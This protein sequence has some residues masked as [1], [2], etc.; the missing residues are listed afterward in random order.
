MR[1][2]LFVALRYLTA[3]RGE[4]FISLIS[5]M[6]VLG[7]VVGVA[8]IIVVQGVM[9]GFDTELKDKIIGANSHILIEA[10]APIE[11]TRFVMD[12]LRDTAG[13]NGASKF[14]AGQVILSKDKTVWGT[15]L[16]GINPATETGVTK[17]EEYLTRG[18]LPV[19]GGVVLGSELADRFGVDV[20]SEIDIISPAVSGK[21]RFHV[22]GIF[23][24]G[25]Y[26]YD[27]NLILAHIKDAQRLFALGEA[28]TGIGV[29]I[30]DPYRARALENRIQKDLG[31]GFSVRTWMDVNRNFFSALKLEKTVM[32]IILALIVVVASFNIA[33]SL[34]MMVIEKTR[35]IGILKSIGASAGSIRRIFALQGF[36]IGA[37]GTAIG[38]FCGLGLA[39]LL[40]KYQ[41]V[42]LPQDIYYIDKIPVCIQPADV[43]LV[44]AAALVI[45][46]LATVYPAWQAARL[47]P[48]AALRYE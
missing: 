25:M 29:S 47:D 32:F 15:L 16:R 28:V 45:S 2:E 7:V 33:S 3:R 39:G 35:D 4:K 46:F 42:K 30:E 27:A 23:K 17:I 21:Q 34:I 31:Y 9:A 36:M 13:V 11:D 26:D 40:E 14:I 8:C 22:A 19:F 5:L 38:V 37:I 43:G 48:V 12:R 10:G 1:F 44:V 41:F 6:S 20:G 24:S 18:S